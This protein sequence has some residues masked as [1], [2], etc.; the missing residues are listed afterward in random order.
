MKLNLSYDI[1]IFGKSVLCDLPKANNMSKCAKFVKQS[2]SKA[3]HAFI[4]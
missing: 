1:I 2:Q 4:C 3:L